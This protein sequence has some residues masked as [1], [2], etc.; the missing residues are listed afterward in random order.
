MS[1]VIVP[2]SPGT[3]TAPAGYPTAN[4]CLSNGVSLVMSDDGGGGQVFLNGQG[5]L[6]ALV[7]GAVDLKTFFVTTLGIP[8]TANALLRAFR[9]LAPAGAVSLSGAMSQFIRNLDIS[10]TTVT[11]AVSTYPAVDYLNAVGAAPTNVP[12]LKFQGPGISGIWRVDIK[13]RHSITN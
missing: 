6:N 11:T 1:F 10:M 5:V 13:L 12:F 2:T 7:A 9:L 8:F 3:I 4:Y